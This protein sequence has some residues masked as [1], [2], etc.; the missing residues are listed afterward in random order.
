M[1]SKR[2]FSRM[3]WLSICPSMLI[4]WLSGLTTRLPEQV[5]YKG[6]LRKH[7]EQICSAGAYMK[8]NG[9]HVSAEKTALMVFTHHPLIRQKVSIRL[10]AVPITPSK[11]AKFI[12]VVLDQG[13]TWAQHV[14]HLRTKAFRGVGLIKLLSGAALAHPQK[15]GRSCQHLCPLEA[16]IWM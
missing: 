5:C 4:I 8:E 3:D 6:W 15:L 14:Q 2:L 13:L 12:G 7:Q 1:I 9:F 16:H 11:H 10:G